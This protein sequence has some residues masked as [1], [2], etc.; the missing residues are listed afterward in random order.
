MLFFYLLYRHLQ[1]RHQKEYHASYPKK[2][3]GTGNMPF[4]LP[5]KTPPGVE[6]RELLGGI[7][8]ARALHEGDYVSR[9]PNLYTFHLS[10]TSIKLFY[11]KV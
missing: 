1:K 10:F 7:A 11:Y 6:T 4:V 8:C 2:I 3:L 5:K 9:T